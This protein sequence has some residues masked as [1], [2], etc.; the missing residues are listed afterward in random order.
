MIGTCFKGSVYMGDHHAKFDHDVVIHGNDQHGG[1]NHWHV[2]HEEHG[3]KHHV[4]AG[5][6]YYNSY[7][8]QHQVI[9]AC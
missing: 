9:F 8:K 3:R 7:H 1:N 6:M 5:L 4:D 2:D